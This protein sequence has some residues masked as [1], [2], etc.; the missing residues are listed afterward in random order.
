MR[1]MNYESRKII[2]F[3]KKN[4]DLLPYMEK[5]FS[6]LIESFDDKNYSSIDE[7]LEII[8]RKECKEICCVGK[9]ADELHDYID[10]KIEENELLHIITS[11]LSDDTADE[12]CDYFLDVSGGKPSNLLVC[13]ER[14][15][16][17]KAIEN[18]VNS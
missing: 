17:L 16:I 15:N 11:S 6:I 2:F 12:I 18:R 10:E 14:E 13:C 1:I 7:I 3:S 8:I 4:L 9:R 5:P